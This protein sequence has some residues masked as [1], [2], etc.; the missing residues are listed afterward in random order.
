MGFSKKRLRNDSISMEVL[1]REDHRTKKEHVPLLC[2][3]AG[4]M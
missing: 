1:K 4:G 2:L 3:I